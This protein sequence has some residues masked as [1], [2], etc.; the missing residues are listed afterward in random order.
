MLILMMQWYTLWE[1]AQRRCWGRPT[2]RREK[3]LG[4]GQSSGTILPLHCHFS[5]PAWN[6]Y[7]RKML[8][9][10]YKFYCLQSNKGKKEAGEVGIFCTRAIL[11]R[12]KLKLQFLFITVVAR[13]GDSLSHIPMRGSFKSSVDILTMMY[14]MYSIIFILILC[15]V[16][17]FFL[18]FLKK[19]I[20]FTF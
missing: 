3:A 6:L 20:L 7:A 9:N 14:I 15:I 10:C 11:S 4:W 8:R 5:K 1:V 13:V 12:L 16:E 2:S 18:F 17:I 19:K